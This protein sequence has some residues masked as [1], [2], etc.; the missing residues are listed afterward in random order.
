[1]DAD[2]KCAALNKAPVYDQSLVVGPE[3][4]LANAIVHLAAGPA[5]APFTP[6][7]YGVVVEI[8][9][10]LF[11]P[12]IVTARTGQRVRFRNIDPFCHC[13]HALPKR[14]NGFNTSLHDN[15]APDA[16][17]IVPVPE[18]I[19]VKSEV[20][21]WMAAYVGVFDHPYHA[22]T[23]ADGEASFSMP[24]PGEH[25]VALWHEAFLKDRL[26]PPQRIRVTTRGCIPP[27]VEFEIR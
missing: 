12:R 18:I 13:I 22:V 2:E 5:G 23:G 9:G 11:Q 6:P 19:V 3:G 26:P 7:E 20:I 14:S 15:T 21:P 25:E 24:P 17:W 27:V 4:Q 10:C 8:K 1:M 16:I